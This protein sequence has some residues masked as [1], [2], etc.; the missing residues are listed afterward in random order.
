MFY[1]ASVLIFILVSLACHSLDPAAR[2]I[3]AESAKEPVPS[4]PD[5]G[6]WSD[7]Q[8][9]VAYFAPEPLQID[10]RLD[11]AS[12]QAAPSTAAFVDIQG[13]GFPTPRFHTTAKMLWDANYFYVGAVLEEPDL[14]ST[15]TERDSVIF[16]DNDFEVFID[17]DG[18]THQYYELE[19]NV[20][21]TEWDL[22]LEKPYRS[23]GPA[24]NAFDTAGLRSAVELRGTIN[25]PTDR[26]LGWSV[27]IAIPW[28]ALTEI[29]DRALPPNDGDVWW[30]NYSRVQWRLDEVPGE[31]GLTGYS[32][33]TDS[34]GKDLSE[35]NWVWSPQGVIAMHEPESWGLVMFA[36]E[37]ADADLNA[38]PFVDPA[39]LLE[40]EF[41]FR[42]YRAQR[43]YHA[44]NGRYSE[45]LV[46]LGL[47]LELDGAHALRLKR[48]ESGFVAGLWWK[49]TQGA[50]ELSIDDTSHVW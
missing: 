6:E 40:R 24:I 50:R 2:P 17:P 7:R 47:S 8:R 18:D 19:I 43:R 13:A 27:E 29:A 12:W 41:L 32:K 20:L 42:I 39:D 22:L 44:K 26:D 28:S 46:E 37:P 4:G 33:R 25:D 14:W 10:G 11:E 35:D 21:G 9:Y 48:T 34:A 36:E 30:V 1:R 16:H 38:R 3:G 31:A 5:H 15:L 45:S 23:G 49:G